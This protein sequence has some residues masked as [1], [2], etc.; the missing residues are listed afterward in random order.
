MD[1]TTATTTET[2][3][4]SSTTHPNKIGIQRDEKLQTL[5]AGYT[6]TKRK[7]E[8]IILTL[9]TICWFEGA[10]NLFRALSLESFC[11]TFVAIITS[12]FVAD[13]LGGVVHWA[14]DTWGSPTSKYFGV[15]IRSFREH[16]IDPKAMTKHDFIEV[17]ADSCIIP[18]PFLIAVTFWR[19]DDAYLIELFILHCTIWTTFFVMMTNQIHKWAHISS[20]SRPSI[21]AFL[22]K[23]GVILK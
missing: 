15:F 16:H 4:T 1:T 13:F 9:F 6:T 21:V 5:A 2:T 18:L 8:I 14:C 20:Y 11:I 10:R 12:M 17:S 22:Q 7:I 23:T 3:Q 19:V